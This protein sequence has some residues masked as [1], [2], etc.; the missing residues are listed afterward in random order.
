MPLNGYEQDMSLSN[1][2]AN[3]LLSSI[4][5]TGGVDAMRNPEA[6]IKAAEVV[7]RPLARH[8]AALPD[9]TALLVRAN[10]GVQVV[11]GTL[12]SLNKFRRLAALVL[13]GSLIPTTLAGHRFWDEI[14]ADK[15]GQQQIE[16]LK[17]MG[18]LGGLILA[19]TDSARSK[20]APGPKKR[21]SVSTSLISKLQ[22]RLTAA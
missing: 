20:V 21:P 5:V 9:D 8:F 10:G 18:I 14:D 1:R 22:D 13:I 4:F 7:T 19:V 11:A 17:N 12:L 16:F 6:R 2:I 3:P 15:R